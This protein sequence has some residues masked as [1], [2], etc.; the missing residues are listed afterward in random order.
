MTN[1][2]TRLAVTGATPN[3]PIGLL[4]QFG[5]ITPVPTPFGGITLLAEAFY[6]IGVKGVVKP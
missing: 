1:G 3:R 4:A 2:V 6:L 5:S